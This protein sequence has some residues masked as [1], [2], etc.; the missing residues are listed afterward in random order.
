MKKR[1]DDHGGGQSEGGKEHMFRNEMYICVCIY[2]YVYMY[3]H[4]YHIYIYICIHT[5]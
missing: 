2:V 3:T 5:C 1:T 4:T